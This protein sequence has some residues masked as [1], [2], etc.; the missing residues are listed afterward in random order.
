MKRRNREEIP[1]DSDDAPEEAGVKFATAGRKHAK[2]AGGARRWPGDGEGSSDSQGADSDD[3]HPSSDDGFSSD[4]DPAAANADIPL[5]QLLALKQD[6]SA[7]AG[8]AARARKAAA[9][10]ATT[11]APGEKPSFKREHKHRPSEMSSKKRVSVLREAF[12]G[13]RHRGRDPRFDPLIAERAQKG[14]PQGA[15][16]EVK[17][18]KRYAF[19]FDEK[20]PEER[21]ELQA[22]LKK[23]KSEGKKAEIKAKLASLA[24][25]SKL[26]A[27]KRKREAAEET[28]RVGRRA[29]AD[30]GKAPFYLKK[31]ERKRQELLAKYEELKSGGGLDRYMEKRRKKNASKDHRYLPGRRPGGE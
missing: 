21:R 29:A 25:A 27:T 10:A 20:V 1:S 13:G 26:E 14:A 9:K 6:G 11:A 8:P 12:Q 7:A 31:S 30:A 24:A 22:A 17:A 2:L 5:G 15:A 23:T 3:G 16:P 4:E 28:E 19:L 18:R